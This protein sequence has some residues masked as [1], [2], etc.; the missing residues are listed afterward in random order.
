MAE[1]FRDY[2]DPS[3]DTYREHV[4][5]PEQ[6]FIGRVLG[7]YGEAIASLGGERL[8][9]SDDGQRFAFHDSEGRQAV[10]EVL[11]PRAIAAVLRYRD[12]GLFYGYTENLWRPD[13]DLTDIPEDADTG[14]PE[15][16]SLVTT[17]SALHQ[18]TRLPRGIGRFAARIPA[19]SEYQ[20]PESSCPVEREH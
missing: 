13:A 17:I 15:A 2:A 1:H 6:G 8:P 11:D 4:L 16:D 3:I 9:N 19:V 18:A 12:I 5:D 20:G 7:R 14:N 10:I